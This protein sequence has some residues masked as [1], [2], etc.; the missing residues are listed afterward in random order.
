ML[1]VILGRGGIDA[2]VALS[3]RHAGVKRFKIAVEMTAT[4]GSNAWLIGFDHYM[5]AC[6]TQLR[7]SVTGFCDL[8]SP[9]R[10]LLKKTLEEFS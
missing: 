3:Q 2:A 9:A 1:H 7:L 6:W 4:R 10:N 5:P 8:L